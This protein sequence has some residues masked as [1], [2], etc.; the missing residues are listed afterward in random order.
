M[1]AEQERLAR[2]KDN[3][4][5]RAQI[6]ELTRRFFQGQD[7]LEVET[8]ARMPAVAPEANIIPLMSEDWYL[9]TSPELHMKRLLAAGYERIFQICRC[10]RRAERGR[11]HN[12][13]CSLLEWYR[14][15]A[16]YNDIIKDTEKLMLFL[17]ARILPDG[18]LS[19]QG[20][21]INLTPPWEHISVRRAYVKYA[22]WDPVAAY[23]ER[24]FDED[25]ALKI[26]P[27]LP[28]DRPVV[29]K[30]YPRE[31]A[32]LARLKPGE[33]D[34]AERAEVFIGGLELANINSELNDR[35]EQM[36]RF[37]EEAARIEKAQGRRA[38]LPQS[39]L[40]AV[41]RMPPAGGAALGLDRL[42]MLLI[43]AASIDEVLAFTV[44]TA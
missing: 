16:D 17:A 4:T 27:S 2:L 26:M 35:K 3:L 25:M 28:Q 7:F 5:R 40:E 44:D 39:F 21:E 18:R 41:G 31:A 24:R 34:I 42:V 9:I 8:P 10:F 43:D 12:P 30:D 6:F 36:W 37:T 38:P 11:L 32:S 23:D 22:A 15:H 29:L 19:Y 13:E 20:R 14:A 1:T 33:P